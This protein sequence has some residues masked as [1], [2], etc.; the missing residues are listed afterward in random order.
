MARA[1]L[2]TK[3]PLD[4]FAYYLGMDP[5]HF[6]QCFINTQDDPAPVCGHPMKQ[7]A[8][9]NVQAVGREDIAYAIHQAESNIERWLGYNLKPAWTVDEWGRT[10]GPAN[11]GLIG[12]GSINVQGRWKDTQLKRGYFIAGGVKGKVLIEASSAV[13]YSDIDGDDYDETAT[14]VTAVVAD[15]LPCEVHLYYP[16][17]SGAD[18]WEIRPIT[19]TVTGLVA[20]ITFRR[21]QCVL[22]EL[23]SVRNVEGVDALVDG[24]FLDEVDVYRVYNDVSQQVTMQ[25]EPYPVGCGCTTAGVCAQ[26]QVSAQAGCLLGRDHRLSIVRYAPGTW[27]ADDEHYD[28]TAMALWHE[29]DRLRLWYLSGWVNNELAC[30]MNQM[31]PFW[32]QVVTYYAA[33]MLDRDICSC[34]N[35]LGYVARWREDLAVDTADRRFT[36]REKNRDNPLGSTRGALNAWKAITQSGRQIGG[37]V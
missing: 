36:N 7:F 20:T 1:S 6:N 24:N 29:P 16:G 4:R 33:S 22:P 5:L 12:M 14:V 35:V 13:I 26:C 27:N 15:T 28:L 8:W 21:E 19:V 11:P 37:L 2:I 9:Q 25:W 23:M 34:E 31:D 3:L 10:T 17:E 18:V 32:E 30:P